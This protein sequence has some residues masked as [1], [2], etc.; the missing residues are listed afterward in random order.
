MT[1]WERMRRVGAPRLEADERNP[2]LLKVQVSFKGK[3]P[4]PTDWVDTFTSQVGD[5][6][7]GVR[8]WAMLTPSTDSSRW[9]T[10]K[11]RWTRHSRRSTKQSISPTTRS[12]AVFCQR[13]KLSARSATRQRAK[14][15]SAARR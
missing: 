13:F 15:E 11:K 4:N 5:L 9:S 3:I 8:G 7:G 6:K 10:P 14:R 12:N 2:N 1:E